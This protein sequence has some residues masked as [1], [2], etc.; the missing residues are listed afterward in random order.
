[1]PRY[2]L[3]IEYDGT[4][5]SG[6]QK[7]EDRATVQGVVE[8]ACSSF[9]AQP[10]E[11]FCAGRTD[12]GVHARGQVA[13]VDFPQARD[14]YIILRGLNTLMLPHPVVVTHAEL[15][16]DDFNARTSAVKRHYEYHIINRPARLALEEFRAWYIRKPLDIAA[17]QEGANHLLGRHDFTTFRDSNCQA[18]HAIRTLDTLEVTR[19]GERVTIHCS[20]KSFLHHQVRNMVGTLALVG[21]GKWQPGAVKTALEALD[22]RAGGPT[23]PAHALYFMRVDY[24]AGG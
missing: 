19:S 20:S 1:M 10:T 24:D 12:A 6:W 16:A 2:K 3:T 11:V 8:A 23:A 17:M 9:V 7:Q 14:P 21:H 4:P 5:F 22:R 15:V 18:K 13:H